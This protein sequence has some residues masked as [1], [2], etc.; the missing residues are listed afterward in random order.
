[1]HIQYLPSMSVLLSV[2]ITVSAC[3]SNTH[4]M[5][6]G[7]SDGD[8]SAPNQSHKA[9]DASS[10]S[11]QVITDTLPVVHP[12]E[13]SVE[14]SSATL[15]PSSSAGGSPM[16]AQI[17]PVQGIEAP[18]GTKPMEGISKASTDRQAASKYSSEDHENWFH[19]F[20]NA[21]DNA[22]AW[23]A[24]AKVLDRGKPFG[25]LTQSIGWEDDHYT[26]LHYAA[27][28]G[29]L[30]VVEELIEKY[31][32]PVHIATDRY[33]RTPLHLAALRGYLKVVQYLVGQGA[34]WSDTDNAKSNVLHYAALGIK[35]QKNTDVIKFLRD[36]G[37]DLEVLADDKFNLLHLAIRTS[38]V[39]LAK[40]LMEQ[41]PDLAHKTSDGILSPL[42][43]A[44]AKEERIAKIIQERLKGIE[45][46]PCAQLSK[47]CNIS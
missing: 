41:C 35:G 28:K 14:T 4:R 9:H 27:Q 43:L 6:M 47:R 5:Y 20:V 44:K 33:K 25:Y 12:K 22:E 13:A 38:N 36:Q 37:A 30:E 21:V 16:S 46:D 45:Q 17:S 11:L 24:I 7:D 26:P 31:K 23:S 42:S 18:I 2:L 1:M 3:Q 8:H 40:Y 34:K 15:S 10:M 39:S 32:V 29:D 19:E